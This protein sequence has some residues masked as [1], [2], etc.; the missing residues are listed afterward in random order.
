[1]SPSLP[2][3]LTHSLTQSFIHSFT[4]SGWVFT[5]PRWSRKEKFGS[6]HIQAVIKFWQPSKF[7]AGFGRFEN[8]GRR[9]QAGQIRIYVQKYYRRDIRGATKT[10]PSVSSQSVSQ[11]GQRVSVCLSVCPS[12]C[13]TVGHCDFAHS[14]RCRCRCRSLS[15]SSV[16]SVCMQSVCRSFCC[17]WSCVHRLSARPS[18]VPSSMSLLSLCHCV[19]A[20][21]FVQK[22]SCRTHCLGPVA[23]SWLR[24]CRC[25][26]LLSSLFIVL[27]P[28]PFSL[29]VVV[30]VVVVSSWRY[31]S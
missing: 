10:R 30:V 12:V 19:T 20:S 6:E 31:E 5:W 14:L 4:Y 11:L 21:L 9:L 7:E 22:R 23:V 24:C 29:F 3:S 8:F 15:V 13:P 2:H 27:S 16:L 26:C 17:C 28:F 18:V 1:M 25:R